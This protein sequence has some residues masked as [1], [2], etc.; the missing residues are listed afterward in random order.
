MAMAGAWAIQGFSMFSVIEKASGRWIGRLGPWRPGGLAGHRGRLGP[1]SAAWGQGYA[2]EAASAAI[3][4][5]FDHLGWTEVIHC[6]DPENVASQA[7]A[8]R[9]GSTNRGPG[10]AAGALPGR[11]SRSG[12]RPASNGGRERGRPARGRRGASRLGGGGAVAWRRLRLAVARRAM[13]ALGA[14]AGARDGVLGAAG[15]F[16]RDTGR[17]RAAAGSAGSGS[18]T[19]SG[20]MAAGVDAGMWRTGELDRR[21]PRAVDR[22]ASR[23]EPFRLVAWAHVLN[24]MLNPAKT[25]NA[26]RTAPVARFLT[27]MKNLSSK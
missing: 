22:Q 21:A 10:R 13:P 11:P 9:L 2:T 4:W 7:V 24:A 5:A 3:D 8:R 15:A 26:N 6:I 12:A 25:E 27:E 19:G 17:L 14:I 18:L 23:A 20:G 16:G 1:A